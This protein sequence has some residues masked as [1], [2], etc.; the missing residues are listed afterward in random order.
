MTKVRIYQDKREYQKIK[1]TLDNLKNKF[2][3]LKR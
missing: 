3:A 2:N 1:K